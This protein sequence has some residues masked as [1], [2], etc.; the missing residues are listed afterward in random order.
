MRALLVASL[1]EHAGRTGVVAAL[2][3]RLAYE[4]RR[5]LALRLG[6]TADAAANADAQFFATL[7]GARGRGSEP[8]LPADGGSAVAQLAGDSIPIVEVPDSRDLVSLAVAL[9]AG[10]VIVWRGVPTAASVALLQNLAL[11]LGV[12]FVGVVVTAVPQAALAAVGTVMDEAALPVLATLSEDRLL[13]SPTIGEIVDALQADLLLGEEAEAQVIEELMIGS[14][15]TDPGQPY[16]SRRGNKAVITRSDKTDMQLAALATDTDCLIL[17]GGF[18]PSPYTL[19]RASSEEVALM[20]TRG[21]TRATIERLAD[22]FG[23]SRFSSE[24]KLE[25]IS[26]LLR[27]RLDWSTITA[28]LG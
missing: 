21:D 17:T 26:D 2:A 23:G 10:V 4:G 12:R 27:E 28:A 1:Q 15:T 11:E 7:P 16:Y 14:I 24:R 18:S 6:A 22:V 25:R 20:V 13:Y 19:D 5:V 3:Q 8:L 9:N